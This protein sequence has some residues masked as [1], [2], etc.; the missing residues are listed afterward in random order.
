IAAGRPTPG[1]AAATPLLVRTGSA[2]G[3]RDAT[4]RT[5]TSHRFAIVGR[6]GG[7][8]DPPIVFSLGAL[9]GRLSWREV[10]NWRELHAKATR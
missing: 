9:A 7:G 3:P 1:V 10:S 2:V 6:Q 4:G 8:A 5:R